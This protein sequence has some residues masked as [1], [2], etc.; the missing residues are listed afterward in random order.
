MGKSEGKRPLIRHKR[1]GKDDILRVLKKY[2]GDSAL[3]TSDSGY[4]QVV[5]SF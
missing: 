4:K 5:G 2:G 3:W 1:R